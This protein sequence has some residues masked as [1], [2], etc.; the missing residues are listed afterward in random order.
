MGEQPPAP[1]MPE[2]KAPRE[3]RNPVAEH[4]PW[5]PAPYTIEN[6]GALQ[7]LMR[8]EALPHQQK[9][10]LDYII[11]VLAG[12]YDEPFRPSQ[13]ETDYALGKAHV[14]R[15]IVKLLKTNPAILRRK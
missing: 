1:R 7:A 12:T 2:R 3:K 14:G 5:K 4:A 8:G 13:R 6:V 11:N 9:E 15:Q 10:A